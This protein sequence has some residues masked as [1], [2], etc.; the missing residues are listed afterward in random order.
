MAKRPLLPRPVA[1]KD[2]LQGLLNPGDRDGLEARRRIRQV[3]EAVVPT[4][5]QEHA[6]LVDLRRKELWVEVSDH[7]W[8]QELQFLKP[9]ILD[10][11]ERTLGP[12]KIR[13]LRIRVGEF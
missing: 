3:W 1:V 10:E 7:I 9:R 13:E 5:L 4:V 6:R 11:L 12:E 8:A 2:V